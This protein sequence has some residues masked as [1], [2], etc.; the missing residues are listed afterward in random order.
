MPQFNDPIQ[1]AT[2][3][4]KILDLELKQVRGIGVFSTFSDIYDLDAQNRSAPYLAFVKDEGKAYL[5]TGS[6]NASLS[7]DDADWTATGASS[8]WQE[9][10][11]GSGGFGATGPTGPDGVTGADGA[12]GPTGPKGATG[13]AGAPGV[14]GPTGPKGATGSTGAN[15]AT[16]P[17][18]PKGATG[19]E[20]PQ[21]LQ[22]PTG[23]TGSEGPQGLRGVTGPTGPK[24]ATGADGIDGATGATGPT[25]PKGATGSEG[26]QGVTGPTGPKGATGSEGDRGV[27]GPTGPRGATG[28]D[29]SVAGPKGATGPTGPKGATGAPGS[30]GATGPTG[31]VGSVK[32]SNEDGAT[33]VVNNPEFLKFNDFEVTATGSGALIKQERFT[34]DY[35]LNIPNDGNIVKSFGKYLNGATVPADGKTAIEVLIDAFQDTADPVPSISGLGQP[36]YGQGTFTDTITIDFGIQ[37]NTTVSGTS[38]VYAVLEWGINGY[39]FFNG[40]GSATYSASQVYYGVSAINTSLTFT[41][42]YSASNNYQVKLTVT[43]AGTNGG[44]ATASVQNVSGV[45]NWDTSINT[46]VFTGTSGLTTTAGLTETSTRRI[47]GN[48]STTFNIDIESDEP[49]YVDISTIKIYGHVGTSL[50]FPAGD[51][52]T[53]INVN[54]SSYTN[55]SAYTHDPGDVGSYRYKIVVEDEHG[56]TT[57]DTES[58][59][60]YYYETY[61]GLSTDSSF[62]AANTIDDLSAELFTSVP[63][64][65]DGIGPFSNTGGSTYVWIAYPSTTDI[66]EISDGAEVITGGFTQQSDVTIT[67]LNGESTTYSVY[68]SNAAGSFDNVTLYLT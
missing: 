5:F 31:T 46:M 32:G 47:R 33:G 53:T 14:T 52:L 67:G 37:N 1:N 34:Q 13:P 21:G 9:V 25:G 56:L 50:S 19:S 66:T 24:G 6:E 38:G 16:G 59:I 23:P 11:L 65:I 26:P 2:V 3:T 42:S 30:D 18:G 36:V 68:R 62:D 57:S 44:Q 4:N 8:Q 15:G 28:A 12:T 43:E 35:V 64:G 60:N 7:V 10:A 40:G 41:G 22:G 58:T 27:T 63:G 61:F 45:A 55:T 54:A 29:S 17:T 20:G 39:G 48:T 51:L 49:S